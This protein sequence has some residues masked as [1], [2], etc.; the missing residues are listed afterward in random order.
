MFVFCSGC[1]SRNIEY[2]EPYSFLGY[3]LDFMYL[4]NYHKMPHFD[5]QKIYNCGKHS[6]KRRNCLLQAISPFLTLFSTIYGTYFS[7]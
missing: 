6:E 7:F 1:W 4:T 3:F 5:A 2:C